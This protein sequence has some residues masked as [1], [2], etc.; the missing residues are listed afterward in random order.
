MCARDVNGLQCYYCTNCN[1]T[2][3]QKATCAKFNITATAPTTPIS[4]T[5]SSSSTD[6]STSLTTNPSTSTDDSV[7]LTTNQSTNTS[8]QST[9]TKASTSSSTTTTL[10]SSSTETSTITNKENATASEFTNV[11]IKSSVEE[12]F[13]ELSEDN[14][15]CKEGKCYCG[16][17]SISFEEIHFVCITD[18]Q[19]VDDVQVINKGCA[20]KLNTSLN[21][22]QQS[23]YSSNCKIC[24]TNLCNLAASLKFSAGFLIFVILSCTIK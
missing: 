23:G 4:T 3:A 1:G 21:T 18:T 7:D 11:S 10:T 16:E 8:N 5:T 2:N 6:G 19:K 14:C 20:V 22:C 13:T 12:M 24:E 15:K 17:R 9:E